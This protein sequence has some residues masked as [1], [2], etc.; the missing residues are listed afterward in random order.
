MSG[1]FERQQNI[2]ETI[3]R[4]GNR[5]QILAYIDEQL[6]INPHRWNSLRLIC[7][8]H[9]CCGSLSAEE[10]NKF[11]GNFLNTFGHKN[12]GVFQ[13]LARANLFPDI[14]R[15]AS[16]N[17][18]GISLPQK[19]TQF[20]NDATKLKLIP[21]DDDEAGKGQKV[22]KACPSYV[23]NG[24]YIPLVAQL[25]NFLLKSGSFTEFSNKCGHLEN[26]KISS[27]NDNFET[28]KNAPN[29]K[30]FPIKPRTLFIFILGGVSYAEVMI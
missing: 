30:E 23:F 8:F 26:L 2:E 1:N 24:N 25:A 29:F 10:S 4:C 13:K 18:M 3:L 16:K 17:L 28:L 19:K 9:V 27:G 6:V 22:A 20:Y 7:L 15:A 12:I 5:K 21:S 11:I 14:G